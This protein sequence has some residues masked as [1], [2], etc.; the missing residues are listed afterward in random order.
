[1]LRSATESINVIVVNYELS[2]TV[3]EAYMYWETYLSIV[4]KLGSVYVAVVLHNIL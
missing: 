2:L 1:M 3:S 4:F